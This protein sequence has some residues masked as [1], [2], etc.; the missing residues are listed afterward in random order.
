MWG[1][2]FA[3]FS[4]PF[5]S[6]FFPFSSWES[7]FSWETNYRQRH[8]AKCMKDKTWHLFEFSPSEG[9]I[10]NLDRAPGQLQLCCF[11]TSIQ[12][13]CSLP[14]LQKSCEHQ[15]RTHR[16]WSGNSNCQKQKLR[17]REP[18]GNC[19]KFLDNFYLP[20][21]SYQGST[22]QVQIGMGLG[23]IPEA[24]KALQDLALRIRLISPSC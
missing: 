14:A 19:C 2:G 24:C 1:V 3:F 12:P 15:A 18:C 4:P 16:Q 23:T 7:F 6:L 17:Q 22:N 10:R 8:T 21:Y 11:F 9:R 5:L 13:W 20:D